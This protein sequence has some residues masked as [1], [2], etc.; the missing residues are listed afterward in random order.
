[1]ASQKKCWIVC[2]ANSVLENN[3]CIICSCYQE[4]TWSFFVFDMPPL[5]C[6]K[7]TV[8]LMHT[9]SRFHLHM[10]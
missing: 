3:M 10:R 6:T 7:I 9:K 5:Q 2:S 1:M 4:G 8:K